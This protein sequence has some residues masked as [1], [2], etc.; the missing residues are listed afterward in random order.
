MVIMADDARQAGRVAERSLSALPAIVLGLVRR[1]EKS[2][3]S[4]ELAVGGGVGNFSA[5]S[6]VEEYA[7]R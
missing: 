2:T 1:K 4:A 6:A 5:V 7:S 3:P